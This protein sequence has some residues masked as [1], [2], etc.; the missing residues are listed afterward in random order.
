[1][2][3]MMRHN[4]WRLAATAVAAVA[5]AAGCDRG[6]LKVKS[7]DLQLSETLVEGR[8]DSISISAFVEYPVAGLPDEAMRN[9][10][11]ALC[12]TAF[13]VDE[14]EDIEKAERIWADACI[15]DY[16]EANM[17][18][19]EYVKG[20]GGES[21]VLS[22]EMSVSGYICGVHG[23]LYSYNVTSYS[24]TG[25]AHGSTVEAGLVFDGATGEL[26]TE[27]DLFAGEFRETLSELLTAH[28]EES[29]ID[30]DAYDALFIKDIEPNGNFIVTSEGIT[31]IYGQYEI[32]PYY[33]GIIKVTVPWDELQGILR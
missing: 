26:V 12:R 23:N 17:D 3:R 14:S 24:Y 13:Q 10:V 30:A 1:M 2:I 20:N 19:L 8:A 6:G 4:I 18:L 28:L 25:G 27:N 11:G 33:L 31:Y 5:V 21:A 22:W 9:I 16:R 29:L 7:A 15:R 32:G